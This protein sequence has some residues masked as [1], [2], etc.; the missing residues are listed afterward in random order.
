M[1]DDCVKCRG[2]CPPSVISLFIVGRLK[3]WDLKGTFEFGFIGTFLGF[4]L[5]RPSLQLAPEQLD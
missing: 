1:E 2:T 5:Q 3:M 4:R